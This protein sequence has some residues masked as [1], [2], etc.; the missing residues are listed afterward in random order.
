MRDQMCGV[1]K[2]LAGLVGKQNQADMP[3]PTKLKKSSLGLRNPVLT[4]R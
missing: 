3:T 2:A 4:P 1:R